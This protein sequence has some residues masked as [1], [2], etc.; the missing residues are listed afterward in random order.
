VKDGV[1]RPTYPEEKSVLQAGPPFRVGMQGSAL[2]YTCEHW[3]AQLRIVDADTLYDEI[4]ANTV[5]PRLTA[6]SVGASVIARLWAENE[7]DAGSMGQAP[8]FVG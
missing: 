4:V 8:K 5:R 2:Q 1:S 3:D 6:P 7:R